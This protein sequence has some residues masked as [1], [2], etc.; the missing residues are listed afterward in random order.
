MWVWGSSSACAGV[1]DWLSVE[2]TLYKYNGSSYDYESYNFGAC[3]VCANVEAVWPTPGGAG[4]RWV[5]GFHTGFHHNPD[6][7]LS[8]AEFYRP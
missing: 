5:E 7:T 1:A 4:W 8:G 6:A 3:F 2:S